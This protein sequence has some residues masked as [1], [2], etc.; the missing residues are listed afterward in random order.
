MTANTSII[1]NLIDA[2]CPETVINS[3][4]LT[5]DPEAQV[6][7]LTLYRREALEQVLAEEKKLQILDYLIHSLKQ[8]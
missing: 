7:I 6:R 2:G 5:D 8:K 1:Q 4:T 3:F